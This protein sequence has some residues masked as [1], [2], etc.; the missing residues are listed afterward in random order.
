VK[1]RE[2]VKERD[3]REKNK[4]KKQKCPSFW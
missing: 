4:G 1:R 3:Q 2:I